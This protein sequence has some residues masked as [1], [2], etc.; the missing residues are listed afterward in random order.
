MELSRAG[1]SLGLRE[2][3]AS[4]PQTTQVSKCLMLAETKCHSC[5]HNEKSTC[6]E[7][8]EESQIRHFCQ[9]ILAQKTD[10]S[11][12]AFWNQ[13]LA[14]WPRGKNVH[15]RKMGHRVK[16]KGKAE[17]HWETQTCLLHMKETLCRKAHV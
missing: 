2:L 10:G 8:G 13:K 5:L 7:E 17:E 3:V 16:G 11:S 15:S 1:A 14:S 6:L 12:A 9:F 4:R